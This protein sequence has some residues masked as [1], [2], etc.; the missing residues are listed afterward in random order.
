MSKETQQNIK[1]LEEKLK[2]V[3]EEQHTVTVS[4]NLNEI[5]KIADTVSEQ[6]QEHLKTQLDDKIRED[7]NTLKDATKYLKRQADELKKET[8]DLTKYKKWFITAMVGFVAFAVVLLVFTTLV[9]M[10]FLDHAYQFIAKK[11]EHSH[12]WY[13]T[14]LWYI[15]Y[16][17]TPLFWIGVV[18]GVA[19]LLHKWYTSIWR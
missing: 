8:E 6:L 14:A 10:P 1:T 7:E 13:T 19:Y 2:K 16:L 12:K 15:A 9:D 3:S 5:Y 17:V 4:L 11:I 18:T